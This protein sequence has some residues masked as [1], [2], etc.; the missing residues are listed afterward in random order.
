MLSR[1][2]FDKIM[3]DTNY[4]YKHGRFNGKISTFL[5]KCYRY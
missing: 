2:D 5:K 4:G 3:L 1:F